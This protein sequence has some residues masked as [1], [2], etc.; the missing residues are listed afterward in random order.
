MKIHIGC[1]GFPVSQARYFTR[2]ET[3]EIASTFSQLPR[4]S[5][6][7]KWRREFPSSAQI[8]LTVW[9]AITHPGTHAAIAR[10]RPKI[11]PARMLR[12]GHFRDTPEVREALRRFEE[13]IDILKPKFLVFRT[14]STFYPNA[15]HLRD[16]YRFFKSLPR[17]GATRIWEPQGGAWD[18]RLLK[19]VCEDL[20][21]VHGVN[22]LERASLSGGVHYYR[23]S[24]L[25]RYDRNYRYSETELA[26][27]LDRCSGKPSYVFFENRSMWRDA[28]RLMA[29]SD[30][31][32]TR[33]ANL[34]QRPISYARKCRLQKPLGRG[35]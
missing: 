5:T 3:I 15:D 9:Q 25:S 4:K 13:V 21:L 33:L 20:G 11:D 22:P 2:F 16:M 26:E 6:L 34:R 18:D 29:L 28:Q 10:M 14:P 7:E 23:L 32:G 17:R 1:S 27:V 31:I 24:G 30:P 35:R 8:A 12:Y 19:K